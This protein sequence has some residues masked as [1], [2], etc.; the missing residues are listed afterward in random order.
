MSEPRLSDISCPRSRSRPSGPGR[1]WVGMPSSQHEGLIE[2]FR[3]QPAAVFDLLREVLGVPL[4][5]PPA[6]GLHESTFSELEPA[7]L[8]ADLVVGELMSAA[9]SPLAVLEVQLTKKAEK[10]WKWPAYAAVLRA[11][12]RR[13]V[14]VVVVA[15]S[16]AVAEWA[17][18]PIR[19]G[20]P[21]SV[22]VPLVLGPGSI[23]RIT[24][25]GDEISPELAVLSVMAHG[26][27][28]GAAEVGRAALQVVDRLDEDRARLYSDLVLSHLS[29]AAQRALEDL[30]KVGNYELQSPIWENLRQHHE[31]QG[32]REALLAFL[33]AR[34]IALTEA[35][36]ARIR[37]C[38]DVA[39]L[40]HWIRRAGRAP[41]A[42]ALLAEGEE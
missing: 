42:R 8:R 40:D 23:P 18:E 25:P 4:P 21:G 28:Q 14:Y 29:V 32:K 31:A 38:A 37:E 30:V 11:Q 26:R 6:V 10:R 34:E 15:P 39:L 13:T 16:A 36:A 17:A 24:E 20:N 3:Q 5:T 22:F 9:Q 19:L 1:T 12:R 35:E 33:A 7:E 27:R 41:D 2:M